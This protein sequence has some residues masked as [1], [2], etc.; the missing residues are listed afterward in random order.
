MS[1]HLALRV[2]LGA[3]LAAS[4]FFARAQQLNYASCFGLAGRCRCHATLTL[5]Y[6]TKKEQASPR[7]QAGRFDDH[8]QRI[9]IKLDNLRLSNEHRAKQ[10]VSFVFDSFPPERRAP[11]EAFSRIATARDAALKILSML[12]ESV[13]N[14]RYSTSIRGLH[15]QQ[16]LPST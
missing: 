3:A 16:G 10:V 1:N 15:L 11:A 12:S 7:P 13:L 5:S 6:M 4:P 2:L 8:R 14:S 9:P